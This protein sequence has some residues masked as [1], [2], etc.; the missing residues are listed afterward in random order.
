MTTNYQ[1]VSIYLNEADQWEGRPLYLEVLQFLKRSGCAGGAV[2]R[3]VAGYTA[4]ADVATTSPVDIERKPPLVV[5]FFD[6]V[7]KISEVLP[8]LR[9]MA[10][11]RLITLLDVHVI[12]PEP[13]KG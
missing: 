5:Q 7:E 11:A 2:L 3:G 13:P 4:S 9:V 8:Q 10:G 1:L 12:P 6:R